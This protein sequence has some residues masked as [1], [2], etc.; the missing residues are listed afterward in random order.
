MSNTN[1]E[2]KNLLAL[3]QVGWAVLLAV[4]LM[5][6]SNKNEPQAEPK[7]AA[8]TAD[9]PH[10]TVSIAETQVTPQIIALWSN[11]VV[12]HL[13]AEIGRLD[14]LIN[15]ESIH[16]NSP[17][18]LAVP[19]QR[20]IEEYGVLKNICAIIADQVASNPDKFFD[21]NTASM[22]IADIGKWLESERIT[23]ESHA[24]LDE[25][26]YRNLTAPNGFRNVYAEVGGAALSI[27]FTPVGVD[28]LLTSRSERAQQQGQAVP[29]R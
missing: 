5:G 8:V 18:P 16:V 14:V 12:R 15:N 9:T 23:A 1:K 28:V 19:A 27:G 3:I 25:R 17:S 24:H 20:K 4:F 22:V 21:K 26:N 6:R 2:M 10:N 11:Q 29:G 13:E 7:P